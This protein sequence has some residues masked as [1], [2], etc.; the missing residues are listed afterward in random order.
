VKAVAVA[1][2]VDGVDGGTGAWLL[3]VRRKERG[4]PPIRGEPPVGV[5]GGGGAFSV[6]RSQHHS[7]GKRGQTRTDP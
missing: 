7:I 1:P 2:P 6:Q 3:E 5:V 4:D